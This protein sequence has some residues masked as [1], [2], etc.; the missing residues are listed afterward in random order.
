MNCPSGWP[1]PAPPDR[2]AANPVRRVGLPLPRGAG[3]GIHW[4]PMGPTR[5]PGRRPRDA[6]PR[7]G[8]EETSCCSFFT[9][10][11]GEGVD[12]AGAQTMTLD[13]SVPPSQSAFSTR[14]WP[15]PRACERAGGGL[16]RAGVVAAAA[17]VNLE[18]LRYY[19]GRGLL[20]TPDR[21]PEAPHL[22]TRDGDHP[23][24]DQGCATA[25]FHARRDRR[26]AD[27]RTAPS[28]HRAPSS[29]SPGTRPGQARRGGRPDRRP[30]HH[31]GAPRR[32]HGRRL[33]RPDECAGTRRLPHPVRAPCRSVSS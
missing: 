16:M 4:R 1:R 29:R 27:R 14:S 28:R 6:G 20:P 9:F 11:F 30:G 18:T 23:P 13:V 5:F 15:G 17:G 10:E 2:G 21:S 31:P 7:P 33:R 32:S 24:G 19:E 3:N 22:R 12:A 8:V 26:P 25:R